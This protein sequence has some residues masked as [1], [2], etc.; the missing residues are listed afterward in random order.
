GIW[1]QAL[2]ALVCYPW[3]GNRR[4]L[5]NMIAHAILLCTESDEIE[6]DHLPGELRS[7][8][9]SATWPPAVSSEPGAGATPALGAADERER[10]L[11]ALARCAGNQTQAAKA[12]GISRSTLVTRL[13]IY[14]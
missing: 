8:G 10:I 1:S 2:G 7:S 14:G 5:R 3:P 4:Q 13:S 11:Q 12:L 6:L 9:P